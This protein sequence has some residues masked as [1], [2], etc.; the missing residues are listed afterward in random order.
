ME[1]TTTMR[2]NGMNSHKND[3]IKVEILNIY[4]FYYFIFIKN[5]KNLLRLIIF[6]INLFLNV[7][8]FLFIINIRNN[9]TY[10]WGLGIGP[11]PQ[12]PFLKLF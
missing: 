10:N 2:M 4:Y 5:D 12:S 3:F 7:L 9:N 11:N 1:K 8:F 6:F